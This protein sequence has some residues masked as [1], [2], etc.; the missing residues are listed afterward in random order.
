MSLMD[1]VGPNEIADML[2]VKRQTVYVWRNRRLIPEPEWTVS[3]S[4]I[5]QR[6]TVEKWA[7][8]TGRLDP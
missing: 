6:K 3:G 1:L 2:G 5:W 8:E 7:K 4:P